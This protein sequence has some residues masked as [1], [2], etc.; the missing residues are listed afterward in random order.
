ML[1]EIH[2]QSIRKEIT[3]LLVSVLIV[4][5]M[6]VAV[7]FSFPAG[8]PPAPAKKAHVV[9]SPDS[10]TKV[11]S[12]KFTDGVL[13]VRIDGVPVPPLALAHWW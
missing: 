2:D 3:F 9:C 11:G 13:S 6:G 4:M 1:P 10:I 5:L 8:S 7:V 12:Y